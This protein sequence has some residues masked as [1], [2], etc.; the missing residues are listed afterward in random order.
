MRIDKQVVR[1][2]D[3]ISDFAERVFAAAMMY[4]NQGMYVLPIRPSAKLLPPSKFG[5]SYQHASRNPATMKKWF[6]PDDGKFAG[7]N[8]ALACGNT[9]GVVAIDI[10]PLDK[11]GNNGFD[12]LDELEKEHGELKAPTQKT[13]SGGRHYLYTFDGVIGCSSGKLAKA[14]DTRGGDGQARG[15]VV[16]WPS[17]T[18]DGDYVWDLD[19]EIGDP[20][21]WIGQALGQPW[22]RQAAA[23]MGRGSENVGDEDGERI[24]SPKEIWS[25]LQCI[26]INELEY[27]EW[28]KI[29]QAIHSQY[30]DSEGLRLWGRWSAGGARF[31]KGECSIRWDKFSAGGNIRMGTL[32]HVAKAYGYKIKPKVVDINGEPAEFADIIEAMNKEWGVVVLGGKTRI[33]P[34]A[35]ITPQSKSIQLMEMQAFQQWMNNQRMAITDAKGCIKYVEKSK[36]WLADEDRN[37]YLGGMTFRPDKT[38]EFED[39]YGCRTLNTWRGWSVE[40]AEGDWSLMKEHILKVVCSGDEK[41]NDWV[42]DWMADLYQDPANPKGCALVLKGQEGTGKGTLIEAMGKTL[43]RHYVHVT[44][45]SHLVGNFNAHLRDALMIFADEVVYG[46]SRKTAGTLK[47]LVTER[48]LTVEMKGFDAMQYRNCARLAIASNEDWVVP[49]GSQSRRWMVLEVSSHRAND[50]SYFTALYKELGGG[51]YEAM[52]AE[53]M[54]REVTS[55]LT[56]AP[57]TK[58]LQE[59]R[60]MYSSHDSMAQWV[61]SILMKG[62]IPINDPTEDSLDAGWPK[63]S[64]WED[65]VQAY[66]EF[67]SIKKITPRPSNLAIAEMNKLGFVKARKKVGSSRIWIRQIP[68]RN[69]LADSLAKIKGMTVDMDEDEKI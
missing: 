45:E 20:P 69:E 29:G 33:V 56:K 46:G 61:Y 11:K 68:T 38:P 28:V 50:A 55:N 64:M 47:A 17:T 27:D 21:E 25:M 34:M 36:V 14:I 9:E 43:G 24:A 62:E 13:P 65:L 31:E 23:P 60:E 22:D 16:A 67:C 32:I 49:A 6:S 1:E 58:A 15:H 66:D 35:R 51:G 37:Q 40:P 53:L 41:L 30:P 39:E 54:E 44:Q 12:S 63:F 48:N 5:I 4:A 10:D 57:T 59:Q 18:P 2:I 8:I 7:W 26:D 19:G 42:L 3:S 52:M